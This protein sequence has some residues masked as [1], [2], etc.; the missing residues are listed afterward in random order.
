MPGHHAGAGTFLEQD[1][2][3]TQLCPTLCDPMDCS[4]EAP[5]SMGFPRQDYWNGLPFPSLGDLPDPG[6]EPGSPI[7]WADALP[8]EPPGSK[9]LLLRHNF[10]FQYSQVETIESLLIFI[11]FCHRYLKIALKKKNPEI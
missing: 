7:L 2:E 10:S 4:L 6:V 9:L 8:S 3:V 1:S 5:L 11:C